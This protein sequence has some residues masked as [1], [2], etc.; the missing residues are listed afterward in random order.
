MNV[1]VCCD[2][3]VEIQDFLTNQSFVA[4]SVHFGPAWARFCT[5]VC[6]AARMLP[7]AG[8]FIHSSPRQFWDPVKAYHKSIQWNKWTSVR[9]G[10]S[11][12]RKAEPDVFD[13]SSK[14]TSTVIIC[15]RQ[16]GIPGTSGII[17]IV[18]MAISRSNPY[19]WWNEQAM[20]TC[21][22]ITTSKGRV[23]R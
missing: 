23:Q 6:I 21:N 4:A 20:S 14:N 7:L 5:L 3:R 19:I 22:I 10:S 15:R 16:Y 11:Y 9:I 18:E 13:R 1:D 2:L 12:E 17:L 8:N